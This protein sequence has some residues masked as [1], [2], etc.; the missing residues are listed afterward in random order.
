MQVWIINSFWVRNQGYVSRIAFAK[1]K[2]FL[3]D[4]MIFDGKWDTG[5]ARLEMELGMRLI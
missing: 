1:T 4:G 2:S 5:T 3:W